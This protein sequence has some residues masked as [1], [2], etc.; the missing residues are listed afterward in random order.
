[1]M[2]GDK[3]THGS[4]W[5]KVIRQESVQANAP[6][7]TCCAHISPMNTAQPSTNPR[8]VNSRRRAGGEMIELRFTRQ[9]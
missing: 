7:K 6:L 5:L 8:T 3:M 9:F 2:K 1:M 4:H